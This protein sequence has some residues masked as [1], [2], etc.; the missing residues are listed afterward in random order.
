MTKKTIRN[1]LT[2]LLVAAMV[3]SM[4]AVLLGG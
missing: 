1:G 3:L 4:L 2:L